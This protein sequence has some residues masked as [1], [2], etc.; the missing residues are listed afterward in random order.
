M[1]AVMNAPVVPASADAPATETSGS[2]FDARHLPLGVLV[3]EDNELNV[4]L[5][6]ELLGQRG[7]RVRVAGDG[8]TALDLAI[9]GRFDLL[10]LDLHMPQMDGFAVVEAI[11]QGEQTTGKHL[12]I[13]A[14][15]ARSSKRDRERS[16]AAGMDEFLSKP[17]EADALWA[18][19][20][21]VVAAFPPAAA[22]RFH[23]LEVNAIL[24]VS[25]GSPA[26]LEKL[27]EVFC[28]TVPEQMENIRTALHNGDLPRLRE[29]AHN[30]YGT[31]AAFST[32][33]GALALTLE[34]SAMQ[35]DLESCTAL[36]ERLDR[37]CTELLEDVRTLM[38][39][40][41]ER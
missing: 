22:T 25:G 33:A 1:W 6:K 15:T 41:L 8:R 32:V 2:T 37:F 28:Q 29:N 11:R 5:L 23:L 4:A 38:A 12:P 10:L 35:E 39:G 9:Q 3:A 14:L 27:C 16:L 13:L 36:V 7:Y 40:G 31:L 34:D 18:A 21:R 17:I 24:R 20:D 26:I 19:I 30:V